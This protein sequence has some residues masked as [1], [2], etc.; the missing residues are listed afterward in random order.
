MALVIESNHLDAPRGSARHFDE[1]T[2]SISHFRMSSLARRYNV[3]ALGLVLCGWLIAAAM[4]L[5]V[6][7]QAA[8]GADSAHCAYCFGLSTSAAPA[9]EWRVPAFIAAP[10]SIVADDDTPVEYRTAPSF[11]LSRGPP[12]A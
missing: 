5:H 7:E 11:Y 3:I 6:K 9:P 2:R 12:A 4:H 8:S 1:M 10:S